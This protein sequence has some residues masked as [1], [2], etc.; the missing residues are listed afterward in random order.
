MG[1]WDNQAPIWDKLENRVK[2]PNTSEAIIAVLLGNWQCRKIR[3]REVNIGSSASAHELF[4]SPT[5]IMIFPL[6]KKQEKNNRFQGKESKL[7]NQWLDSKPCMA[8]QNS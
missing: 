1:D 6:L 5:Q 2:T 3:W 4:H 7:S 8:M